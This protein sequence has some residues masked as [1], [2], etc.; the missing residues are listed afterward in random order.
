MAFSHHSNVQIFHCLLAATIFLQHGV[1]NSHT[2]DADFSLKL[3]SC[4]SKQTVK[5]LNIAMM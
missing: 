1:T 4:R 2:T 3:K 5:N